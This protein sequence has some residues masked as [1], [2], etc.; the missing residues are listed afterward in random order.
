MKEIQLS[1]AKVG[2]EPVS[3]GARAADFKHVTISTE[4]H[5]DTDSGKEEAFC[6]FACEDLH[7]L[8]LGFLTYDLAFLQRSSFKIFIRGSFE[9]Q[10]HDLQ[11]TTLS[12]SSRSRRLLE[13]FTELQSIE[14]FSISGL[15]N[16]QCQVYIINKVERPAPTAESAVEEVLALKDQGNVALRDNQGALARTKHE[17]AIIHL[18]SRSWDHTIIQAGQLAS[19]PRCH[20]AWLLFWGL[21]SN[22]AATFLR[23]GIFGDSHFWASHALSTMMAASGNGDRKP[24]E[25]SELACT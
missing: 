24:T 17:A 22:L 6:V 8:C 25:F 9:V 16:G 5:Q 23:M 20:A 1:C 7:L 19:L 12:N 14:R 3:Y 10:A 21:L 11:Y 4:Y 15:V 2:L 18:L 13:P